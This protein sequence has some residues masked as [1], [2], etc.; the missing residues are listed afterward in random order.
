MIELAKVTSSQLVD[1]EIDGLI[2]SSNL[3]SPLSESVEGLLTV[4][5][6]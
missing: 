4:T 1:E 6:R 5:Q 2:G 3:V